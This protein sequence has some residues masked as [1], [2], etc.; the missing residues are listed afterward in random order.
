MTADPEPGQPTTVPD[1]TQLIAGRYRLTAEIGG[2]AMGVV[3]RAR[4]EVLGREVAVK[5]LRPDAGMSGAQ[6]K[7][8]HLRARREGRIAARLQHP[9]AVTIYDVAEHDGRPYLIMEFVPS[10]TLADILATGTVLTPAEVARIGAQLASALAAA[11]DVGIVHRDIKPGNV[12]MTNNGTVKLTDFGISRATGDATVTSTGEILGTPAYTAPEVAQGHDVDFPA[13]VFSLGATLY[14][15]VEGSPPF[16]DEVNAMAVLL[17]VVRNEIRPPRRAGMLTDTVL[18]MLSPEPADRPTMREARQALEALSTSPLPVAGVAVGSQLTVEP[19]P[20]VVPDEP[21]AAEPMPPVA[22]SDKPVAAEPTPPVAEPDQGLAAGPTPS[23]AEPDKA[24]A[25]DPTPVPVPTPAPVRTPVTEKPRAAE[26]GTPPT[27]MLPEASGTRVMVETAAAAGGSSGSRRRLTLAAGAVGSAAV[28]VAI[29]IAVN[30]GGHPSAPPVALSTSTSSVSTAATTAPSARTGASTPA[31]SSAAP[32]SAST[33]AASSTSSTSSAS[34]ASSTPSTSASADIPTQLA[35]A[36][37][38]YYSLVPGN[39]N[40]AWGLMT[41]DYQQ[42]KALGF[43]NYR[44]FWQSMQKVTVS[45]VVAKAPDTVIATIG[46]YPKNDAPSQERT[47]FTLVQE[48][49]VWKIAHS[50]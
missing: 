47:T 39:L 8:S 38:N 45:D 7:Q 18:G 13:D 43:E 10:S 5:E 14:A 34:S 40:Q 33:S 24:L 9:N 6:V 3:W 1:R 19:T 37:T 35:S 44:K 23:V 16:G 31:P 25:A 29:I 20:P 46:Y 50:S 4:D 28:I 17:R 15:A 26:P 12:L 2:G 42:H 36:I 22:I 49:G 21:P 30:G 41:A 11:H 32:S 27:S 48:G